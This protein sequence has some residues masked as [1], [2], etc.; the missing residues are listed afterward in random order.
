MEQNEFL[1]AISEAMKRKQAGED[2]EANPGFKNRLMPPSDPNDMQVAPSKP[3]PEAAANAQIGAAVNAR[4]QMNPVTGLPMSIQ[5]Q[6]ASPED[7]QRRQM[8][9]FKL[10]YLR[11]QA[12]Q[13]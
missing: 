6:P 9:Q 2:P 7:E 12:G 3:D 11:K 5:N 10:D 1:A 13:Q 8:M 4:Q